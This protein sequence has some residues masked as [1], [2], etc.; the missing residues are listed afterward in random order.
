LVR[1]VLQKIDDRR[2]G[3]AGLFI[4]NQVTDVLKHDQ[5]RVGKARPEVLLGFRR[6]Q[7]VEQPADHEYRNANI[8][9]VFTH[10]VRNGCLISLREAHA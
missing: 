10:G 9:T 3:V 8:C 1:Q 5:P 7:L 4:V 2:G 6:A